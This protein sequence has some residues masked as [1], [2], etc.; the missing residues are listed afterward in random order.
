MTLGVARARV[1]SARTANRSVRLSV[2]YAAGARVV[3]RAMPHAMRR[4]MA[5]QVVCPP[6]S[7][8]LTLL[9]DDGALASRVGLA[10]PAV[11]IV[12]ATHDHARWLD[13]AITSVRRQTVPDWEL[14]VVDD[15]STDDTREVV[16]RHAD[17]PRIRYLP[18]PHRER[19]AARNRGLAAAGAQVVAFLDAD[20][21]WQPEKLARQMAALAA[22]PDA[23]LCY[24]IARFVD[25]AG[26]PLPIRKP[27]RAIAGEV[28]PA[29][30][31]GNFIILASV[32]ARRRC[33]AEAGGF[34]E[35]L[36]VYGCEDWDLWLRIARRHRVIVVDEELTL[37]RRHE[38]NTGV[39]ALLRSG[40]T[41]LDRRY[42]EPGTEDA[43][44]LSRAAARARLRW[45]LAGAV[46]GAHR[47]A[48]VPLVLG[49]L[50]EAPATA[51]ARPALG[52]LAAL[53]LPRAAERALRRL[54]I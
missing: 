35:T 42:A 29:L 13:G 22:A 34:D 39:D 45:Y 23:A 5:N 7:H 49:A 47:G 4:R 30:M 37:Y 54:P 51:L 8:R 15:G 1:R 40:L 32:V 19:A 11:S 21:R 25:A 36:P 16:A 50:R 44:R 14:L 2:T 9:A 43:A 17:D 38:G 3:K 12:L 26:A 28:F 18:G 20:D 46:A 31:R 10:V 41:V 53:L 6:G 27:P 52:A 24:T 48:A 33:L